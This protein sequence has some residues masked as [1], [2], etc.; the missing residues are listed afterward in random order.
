[1]HLLASGQS[2]LTVD[3]AFSFISDAIAMPRQHVAMH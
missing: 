2:L 1:M 3:G